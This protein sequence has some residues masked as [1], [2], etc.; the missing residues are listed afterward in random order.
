[1][2]E[3]TKASSSLIKN[4]KRFFTIKVSSNSIKCLK[5]T[6]IDDGGVRKWVVGF[7]I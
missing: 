3:H 5:T 4:E 6:K 7:R 2:M 1:M